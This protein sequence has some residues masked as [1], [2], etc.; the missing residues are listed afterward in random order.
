M[1]LTAIDL[2]CGAGGSSTGLARA[3]IE[4]LQAANHWELA[5]ASHSANHPETS[6]ACVDIHLEH[7]ASF[8][9]SAVAWFSPECRVHSPAGGRKRKNV[10]QLHLWEKSAPQPEDVRSRMTAWDCLRFVEFHRQPF[11]IVEN[12]IEFA[13]WELFDNWLGCFHKLGYQHQTVC[14]NSQFADPSPVAQSRDR[15]YM[16]FHREDCPKPKVDFQP[17]GY[18]QHCQT[19]TTFRQS[20]KNPLRRIGRYGKRHQY[21]Y[22]CDSCGQEG[23]PFRKPAKDALDWSLPTVRIG[24]RQKPLSPNTLKRIEKGLKRFYPQ[25]FLLSNRADNIPTSIGEPAKTVTSGDHQGWMVQPE[26][27]ISSYYGNGGEVQVSEPSPTIRTHQ[28]HAL[29]EPDWSA[30][31]P[32]CRYRMLKPH[33]AKSLMGF[34]SDYVLLGNQRQ[35]FKQA[36]N[37]VTPAV[38]EMLGRAIKDAMSEIRWV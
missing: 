34:P 8:R 38:A 7:P 33:E 4:V 25:E 15:L 16:V 27:F 28:G 1:E 12:V 37:A 36:G 14:F 23:I 32:D 31:V 21:V 19:E 2:F 30:L 5:I 11:V 17:P 20:W 35:Q 29:I 3:G 22:R 10:G 26:P 6:H 24:D 13:D 18:C 9:Q